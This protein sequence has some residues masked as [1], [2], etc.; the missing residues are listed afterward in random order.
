MEATYGPSRWPISVAHLAVHPSCRPAAHLSAQLGDGR[1]EVTSVG[2]Q[3]IVR[4]IC[5]HKSWHRCSGTEPQIGASDVDPA[6][7]P[8]HVLESI[9]NI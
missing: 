2:R 8:V 1:R 4:S 5:F 9:T 3:Y 6:P 7:G